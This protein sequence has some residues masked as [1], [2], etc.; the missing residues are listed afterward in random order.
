MGLAIKV[1]CYAGYKADERPLRF[2]LLSPSAQAV[3]A[4]EVKKILDQ[5]YGPG[6]QC[7]RLCAGD[8]NVYVLRHDLNEDRWTLDSPHRGAGAT[9]TVIVAAY[10]RSRPRDNRSEKRL[11]LQ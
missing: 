6:Y 9:P 5:W 4:L 2:S 11:K 7:F 1:E 3:R 8:K 10:S